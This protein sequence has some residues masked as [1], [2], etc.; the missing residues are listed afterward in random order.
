[1]AT[2]IAQS[3]TGTQPTH[4]KSAN[5]RLFTF[6]PF[7]QPPQGVH[8]VP[9]P[10]FNERGISTNPG[11]DEE[12]VDSIG[13]PTVVMRVAHATDAR[14]T[15]TK[16]KK[17]ADKQARGTGQARQPQWWEEWAKTEVIRLTKSVDP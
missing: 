7:P 11:P 2:A 16:R 15:N 8:I 5:S 12:E 17:K 10:D 13:I 14:K 4:V 3:G 6:P 9:F 1:M